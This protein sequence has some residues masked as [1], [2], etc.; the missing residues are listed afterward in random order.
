MAHLLVKGTNTSVS[1]LEAQEPVSDQVFASDFRSVLQR[2]EL[3]MLSLDL[4]KTRVEV[5]VDEEVFIVRWS[6]WVT[7]R[8]LLTAGSSVPISWNGVVDL[9]ERNFFSLLASFIHGVVLLVKLIL[10]LL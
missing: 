5:L 1:D 10:L 6:I 7:V 8:R 9:R 2:R 4:S 3:T